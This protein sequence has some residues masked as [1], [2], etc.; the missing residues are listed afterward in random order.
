MLRRGFIIN[1]TLTGFFICLLAAGPVMAEEACQL[2]DM[3]VVASPIIEGNLVDRYAGQKTLVSEEQIDDLNA[4]D[5]TAALRKT[6]GVNISRYNPV[7]SFGGGEGGAVFIRGMGSSRPGAEIKTF[8]DG[9]PMY[10]SIWNHP[11]MDLMAIDMARS[12]E[13]YKNPQPQNFGN[14][15]AAVNIVPRYGTAE[16]VSSTIEIAAGSYDTA[17]AKAQNSG[18]FERSDYF[19]S[20][21]YHRSDGHR[22]HSEGE[23]GNVY[24]RFGY[25]LSDYWGINFL[26]LYSDNSAED[27]GQEGALATEREGTYETSAGLVTL[28]LTNRF[29]GA[30]GFI[31]FYR[32]A[33]EGDWLDQPTE[34]DGVFEDLY[35]DFEFYG[36][37]SREA[38]SPWAGGEIITGLDWECTDGDYRKYFS[39]GTT[40]HWDGHDFTMVSPYAAVSHTIGDKDGLTVTPS[41]GVRY[42]DNSDFG[43]KYAPHAGLLVQF[44]AL[45]CHAGYSR[46]VVYPGL[47]V[48]AFSEEVIPMLQESWKDLDPEIMDHYEAGIA[49]T[50]GRLARVELTWFYNDG[51]DRYVFVTPPI[52]SKPVYDNVEKY[53]TKGVEASVSINPAENLALFFG[54]TFLRSDPSDLPYAPETTLS[55]GLNWCFLNKFTFSADVQYLDEMYVNSQVRK[56]AAE[57]TLT[58]DSY[59]V[60]NAKLS[61]HFSLAQNGISGKVFVAGENLTDTDYEYR[62]GY[63][64]PGI[65][66][67]AGVSLMF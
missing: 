67:M 37:K 27:P 10:M 18:R 21:G 48:V 47:D 23:T 44:D 1:K 7:G 5:I 22:S 66:G 38:F 14:A 61:Y 36:V 2:D 39:D 19:I 25:Q 24:G 35:N 3:H 56:A 58:V 46:G 40:D 64:M 17:I 29:A 28:T 8:I 11:L 33:G 16:G 4:Q 63:P 9:V 32:N 55:S 50:F 26:G 20:G 42:Y 30:D 12:V 41:A 65:N 62:P 52:T 53:V 59:T 54:A 49:R 34:T 15:V 43:E 13:V 45:T 51:K 6:P 60:V 31:K 57:N